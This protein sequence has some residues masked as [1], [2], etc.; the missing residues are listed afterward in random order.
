LLI[1]IKNH[2]LQMGQENCFCLSVNS[3]CNE[4]VITEY[5]SVPSLKHT[6]MLTVFPE[7]YDRCLLTAYAV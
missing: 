4:T 1:L 6:D 2:V 3:S 5:F 7:K